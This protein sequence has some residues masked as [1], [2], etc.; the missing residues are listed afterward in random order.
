ML[1]KKWFIASAA[2]ALLATGSAGVVAGANLQQIKAY[3]NNGLRLEVD[4]A[5]YTLKDGNGKTLA[6]I[7]Y[8]GLTYLPTQALARALDVPIAYDPA[9]KKIEI[10]EGAGQPKQ[11]PQNMPSDFPIPQD[12]EITVSS[13]TDVGGVLQ[14]KLVYLTQESLATMGMVYSEY[15]RIKGLGNAT[16]MVTS[17]KVIVKGRLGGSSPLSVTGAPSAEKKGYNEFT[18]TYSEQ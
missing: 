4:G 7:T 8:E 18:I 12:A 14:S 13:D 17:S 16:Q 2:A 6:P 5:P 9:A 15:G 1:K 10:G 11:R 3:L